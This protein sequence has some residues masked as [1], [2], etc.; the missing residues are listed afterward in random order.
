MALSQD[1]AGPS[2]NDRIR[3]AVAADLPAIGACIEASYRPYVAR[4]GREPAPMLADYGALVA[5][6]QVHVVDDDGKGDGEGARLAGL[7][8]AFA[9]ADQLFI[10]TL[11]ID[12]AIQGRGLGRRFMD[13]AAAQAEGLGLAKIRLYT[14][15]H[16][17]EAQSF[18]LR[19]GYLETGRVHEEGYDRIYYEKSIG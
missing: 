7:L 12:P 3:Q 9:E 19:L 17:T 4:M 13:F 1:S 16:M 10:E 18:Y 15:V 14:N 11:A 2:R 5:A 8:V 6:G